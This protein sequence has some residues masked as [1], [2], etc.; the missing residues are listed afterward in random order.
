MWGCDE[1]IFDLYLLAIFAHFSSLNCLELVTLS[2]F[3]IFVGNGKL[4]Y[5]WGKNG[6]QMELEDETA[7][8]LEDKGAGKPEYQHSKLPGG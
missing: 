1:H 7:H 6:A 3:V 4:G 8:G 2:I 5:F